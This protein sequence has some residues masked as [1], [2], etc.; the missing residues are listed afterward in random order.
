M[1]KNLLTIL[2]IAGVVILGFFVFI[3]FK[4]STCQEATDKCLEY[5]IY[6]PEKKAYRWKFEFTDEWFPTKQEA[7]EN[8]FP[9]QKDIFCR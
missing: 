6:S 9:V 4:N 7:M 2:T 5:V 3:W 1:K 8:C